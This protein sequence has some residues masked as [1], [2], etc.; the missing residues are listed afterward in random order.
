MGMTKSKKQ[1]IYFGEQ[2]EKK[3]PMFVWINV[4]HIVVTAHSVRTTR[5]RKEE[6]YKPMKR[7]IRKLIGDRMTNTSTK[8]IFNFTHLGKDVEVHISFHEHTLPFKMDVLIN[9]LA[10]VIISYFD[11]TIIEHPFVFVLEKSRCIRLNNSSLALHN[12]YI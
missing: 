12:L 3:I 10:R 5:T 6:E 2:L 11:D 7:F 8:N 4:E 1:I 9:H